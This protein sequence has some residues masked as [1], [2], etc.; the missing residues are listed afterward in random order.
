MTRQVDDKAWRERRLK[1]L[2]AQYRALIE[3]TPRLKEIS[4]EITALEKHQTP[5]SEKTVCGD[6]GVTED[7]MHEYECDMEVC[8]F[9]VGQLTSCLCHIDEM[10]D[11][12]I[13]KLTQAE[14]NEVMAIFGFE[15]QSIEDSETTPPVIDVSSVVPASFVVNPTRRKLNSATIV[16]KASLIDHR[17]LFYPPPH[18]QAYC[19][20]FQFL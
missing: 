9:C 19:F 11:E 2:K 3:S 16:Q 6:C 15:T 10:V 18:L 12:R 17:G 5:S 20:F 13:N 4:H 7:E 8:L 1:E 14:K